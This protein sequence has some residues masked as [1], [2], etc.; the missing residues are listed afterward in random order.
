MVSSAYGSRH[1]ILRFL[2]ID[3]HVTLDSQMYV[4]SNII[5]QIYFV[6]VTSMVNVNL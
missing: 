5:F 2:K 3:F 6:H 1:Y 4:E